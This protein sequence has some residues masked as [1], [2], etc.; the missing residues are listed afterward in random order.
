M[1]TALEAMTGR[2]PVPAPSAIAETDRARL[3]SLGYGP[4][5]PGVALDG[6]GDP[7]RDPKDMVGVANRYFEACG[8]AAQGRT[9]AAIADWRTV[10]AE[11]PS[12]ASGWARLT[13]LLVAA[14]RFKEAGEALTSLLKLYPEDGRVAEA[15]RRLQALLGPEPTADRFAMVAAVW[16]S[17]GE[18][19]RASDVRSAAR[20]AV[21]DAALRKAEAALR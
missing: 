18:K 13:D 2:S 17:L 3:A 6:P 14:G 5:M 20:K 9:D 1:R 7:L 12:L 11:A 21:G 16:T 10:V 8:L 19:A 15:D 4:D